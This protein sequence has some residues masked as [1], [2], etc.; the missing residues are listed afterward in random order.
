MRN[1]S[2]AQLLLFIFFVLMILNTAQWYFY[3]SLGINPAGLLGVSLLVIAPVPLF[4]S[5]WI[6]ARGDRGLIV[7]TRTY[8]IVLLGFGYCVLSLTVYGFAKGNLPQNIFIDLWT[9]AIIL[10]FLILGVR[11]EFWLDIEKP[12]LILFWSCFVIVLL[13]TALPR[14]HLFD[15]GYDLDYFSGSRPTYTLAYDLS[16]LLHF[17]PV[18]FVL[19]LT[20]AKF[21]VWKV[22]GIL[23]IVAYFGFQIYFQ[24]RAPAVRTLVYLI[25]ALVFLQ[26]A[27]SARNVRRV[28]IVALTGLAGLFIFMP[29]D[30][31]LGRFQEADGARLDEAAQMIGGFSAIDWLVGR[32]FGGYFDLGPLSGQ[33]A[34]V[35]ASSSGEMARTRLHIGLLYPLLKGGLFFVAFHFLLIAPMFRKFQNKAWRRDRYNAVAITILPVYLAFRSIEGAPSPGEFFDGVIFAICCARLYTSSTERY[36]SDD[37]QITNPARC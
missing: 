5:M 11:D 23:T 20:R 25:S 12:M 8:R 22:L 33:F 19:G 18:L 1:R 24:K 15:M 28:T 30:A 14:Q 37:L 3:N 32:G 4:L 35:V 27:G 13:S 7:G 6:Y 36:R 10:C 34:E 9:Y 29:T 2:L 31:F 16:R 17:W 26:S 21:D